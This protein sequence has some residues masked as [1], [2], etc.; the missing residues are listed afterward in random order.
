MNLSV[1]KFSLNKRLR[2]LLYRSEQT[3]VRL[4]RPDASKA[5]L[6]LQAEQPTKEVSSRD[7]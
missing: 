4:L 6:D 5:L 2:L 1:R 7:R 3:S